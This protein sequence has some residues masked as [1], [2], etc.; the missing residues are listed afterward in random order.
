MFR[1]GGICICSVSMSSQLNNYEQ[2]IAELE[3][4]NAQLEHMVSE[5]TKG[6]LD[7][8]NERSNVILYGVDKSEISY[9]NDNKKQAVDTYALNFV[10]G[11]LPNYEPTDIK[12]KIIQH[13]KSNDIVISMAC[14]ADAFKLTKRCRA[15]GFTKL[16]QGLTKPERMISKSVTLRTAQL[17]SNLSKTSDKIYMKRHIHS[18]AK[19][20]KNEPRSTLAVFSPEFNLTNLNGTVTFKST[21][22]IRKTIN[23]YDQASQNEQRPQIPI[24]SSK[25]T[26]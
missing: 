18:I 26:F 19:V 7:Y 16:R 21:N 20:K 2:R 25:P 14:S 1:G 9:R 24:Q 12:T 4:K 17:N 11:Y 10:R 5:L 22:M 15:N 23:S 8:E 3:L 13:D 6:S